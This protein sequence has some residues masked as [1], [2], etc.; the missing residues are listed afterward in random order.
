MIKQPI[1][2]QML[3]FRTGLA[4]LAHTGRLIAFAAIGSVL[5]S[6]SSEAQIGVGG[7]VN[8]VVGG[9][10]IDANGMVRDAIAEDVNAE[11]SLL[12]QQLAGG[13]H[14]FAI[15]AAMR[16]ISLKQLQATIAESATTGKP[17]PEEVLLLGGLTRVEY[18]MVFPDE[19]DIVIAGPSENWTVGKNGSIVGSETGRPIVYLDDLL[20]AFQTADAARTNAISCSIDPTPEGTRRLSAL[21]DSIRLKPGV[22]P[23]SFEPAMRN[24]FGLQKVT[25][26]GLPENSHMARVIFAADVGRQG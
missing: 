10:S 18:V 6:S 2:P 12:R 7:F 3:R 17:L 26:N 8:R 19:Q 15:P 9:V 13:K 25:L 23:I 1:L 21:L 24:A 14:D 20:T 22:N 11:L 5:L 4:A 16:M